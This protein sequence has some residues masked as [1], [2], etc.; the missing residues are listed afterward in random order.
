MER[1]FDHPGMSEPTGFE[2]HQLTRSSSAGI[3]HR[4]DDFGGVAYVVDVWFAPDWWTDDEV[5]RAV[6]YL[7]EPEHCQHAHDCCGRYY[8][9]GGRVLAIRDGQRDE[10]GQRCRL[11]VVGT[12]FTQNV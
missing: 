7:M 11:V 12:T 1:P 6:S 9:G 10:H 8:S 5:S 3:H 4:Y 2:P